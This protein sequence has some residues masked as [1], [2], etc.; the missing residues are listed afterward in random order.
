MSTPRPL[1]RGPEA[2]PSVS[3]G[4]RGEGRWGGLHHSCSCELHLSCL[5]AGVGKT[6]PLAAWGYVLFT[7]VLRMSC[8][9]RDL[10]CAPKG[11]PGDCSDLE[12]Q[13]A[14]CRAEGER[15][16]CTRVFWQVG[17]GQ[18]LCPAWVPWAL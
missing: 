18:P 6:R 7:S 17:G 16:F 12:A 5:E 14:T 10:E 2:P 15:V 13:A 9:A 3:L 1:G 11:H 8:T 4:Q